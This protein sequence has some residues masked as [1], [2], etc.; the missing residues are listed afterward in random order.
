MKKMKQMIE[1]EDPDII[2]FQELICPATCYIPSGYK[3]VGISAHHQMYIKKSSGIKARKH[4]FHI[5]YEC[6]DITLPNGETFKLFNV[7]PRWEEKI[8]RKVFA[9][10]RKKMG[11]NSCILCGDFNANIEDATNN[12]LIGVSA[13]I[14]LGNEKVDTFQNYIRDYQHDEIDHFIIYAY[15]F[16]KTHR[17]IE[18]YSMSDHRPVIIEY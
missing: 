8:A 18:D 14:A 9:D 3:K 4:E 1:D 6:A 17:V 5:F 13:R 10:I 12:G 15:E 11:N 7:H 2:C 16:P